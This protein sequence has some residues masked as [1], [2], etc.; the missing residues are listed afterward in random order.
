MARFLF[1][2]DQLINV[3]LKSEKPSGGSA[4]QTYGWIRGLMAQ[5]QEVVVM[6]DLKNAG[7]LKDSCRDI[8]LVPFYDRT[9]GTRWL[10]WLYYRI[11]HV[12]RTIKK[13]RA[14]YVYQ[15]VP[16][17]TTFI[18]GVICRMLGIKLVV[19]ISN[20]FIVDERIFNRFSRAYWFLQ[21]QGIGMSYCVLCQNKYQYRKI[22]ERFPRK[23]VVMIANPIFEKYKGELLPADE[24][25]YIAWIGIF[26]YQ[27]NIPLLF[28]IA[29]AHPGRHFVVAGKE[30]P[31]C[32]LE[33]SQY[34]QKLRQLPNVEFAGFLGRHAVLDCIAHAEYLLNTSHYEGFS[35]TFLEAMCCGTPILTTND[36]NPDSIIS[37]NHLGIVYSNAKDLAKK[38]AFIT[39]ES[40]ATLS[41]NN[42]QYV[43]QHHDYKKLAGRLISSLDEKHMDSENIQRPLRKVHD[44]IKSLTKI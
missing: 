26:Q 14:D 28:E 41:A 36:V 24:R 8:Q 9:K 25:K 44:P 12:Y 38:L 4:V 37:E 1:F 16:G 13:S 11:P 23:K 29:K 2:D 20:D 17:W 3:L 40:Y 19:R 43:K 15:G 18:L 7:D 22:S 30:D 5:G 42:Y 6:T 35:N 32:D 39:G 10:R 33:T 21:Q 34:L 27:K 31:K